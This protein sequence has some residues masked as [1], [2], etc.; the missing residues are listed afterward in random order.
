MSIKYY[1]HFPTPV[2]ESMD[3]HSVPAG[4]NELSVVH[5]YPFPPTMA[6]HLAQPWVEPTGAMEPLA[7]PHPTPVAVGMKK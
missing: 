4:H 7:L 6:S 1:E 3:V 2:L 5:A